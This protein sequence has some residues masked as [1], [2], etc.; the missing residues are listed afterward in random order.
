MAGA[1]TP[2]RLRLARLVQALKVERMSSTLERSQP[3]RLIDVIASHALHKKATFVRQGVL[4]VERSS[5]GRAL[6]PWKVRSM[7]VQRDVSRYAT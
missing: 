2:L 4:N 6:A 1:L 3:D 7:L 5:E